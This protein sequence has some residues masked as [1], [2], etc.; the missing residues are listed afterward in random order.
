MVLHGK[1]CGR[2][3]RRRDLFPH[4]GFAPQ[5][6]LNA[7]AFR[8]FCFCSSRLDATSPTRGEPRRSAPAMRAFAQII[9]VLERA[10]FIGAV[11]SSRDLKCPFVE[12]T[13][14]YGSGAREAPG[15]VV[16]LIRDRTVYVSRDALRDCPLSEARGTS[17]LQSQPSPVRNGT[18]LPRSEPSMGAR[19]PP[20]SCERDHVSTPRSSSATFCRRK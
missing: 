2:V 1:P 14:G 7:F 11:S 10:P 9:P 17:S 8:P 4:W 19:R 5:L 6:G 15:D 18:A 12:R 20:P 13:Q 3:G 16:S